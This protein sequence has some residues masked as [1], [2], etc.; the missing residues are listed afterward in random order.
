MKAPILYRIS[1]ILLLLFAAVDPID[2]VLSSPRGFDTMF[3]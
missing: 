3:R 2:M 1:S